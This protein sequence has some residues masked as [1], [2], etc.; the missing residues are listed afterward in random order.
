MAF[1]LVYGGGGPNAYHLLF[2]AKSLSSHPLLCQVTKYLLYAM[3][4]HQVSTLDRTSIE[5]LYIFR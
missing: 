2:L 1:I 3:P 5:H 4:S